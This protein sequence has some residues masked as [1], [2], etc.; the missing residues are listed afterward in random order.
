MKLLKILLFIILSAIAI[1]FTFLLLLLIFTSICSL[2]V[3]NKTYEKDSKF[4]R[5]LFNLWTWIVIKIMRIKVET[6]GLEKMPKDGKLLFVGNH[7]SNFDPI[8]TWSVFKKYNI[9]YLSKGTNFK[10]PIFGKIVKRCCFLEIDRENSRN[11]IRTIITASEL[12]KKQELSI[13]VYPEGTRNKTKDILLP[14]HNG[15]FKIAQKA[16]C[17]IVVICVKGT[18][19]IHRN[20]PLKKSIV[21]LTVVDV[22]EK[23]DVI[24]LSSHEIGD[25]VKNKLLESLKMEV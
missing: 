15:V 14:F 24:A 9:S 16:N 2:F 12:I 21:E 7:K 13:G 22:I 10:I 1:I 20:Y 23:N 17:P 3:K 11:A 8:I 4:Y 25:R 5:C 6:K 18:S 19:K